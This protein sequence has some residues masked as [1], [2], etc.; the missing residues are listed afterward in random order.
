MARSDFRLFLTF[1]AELRSLWMRL[2]S[3]APN[4]TGWGTYSRFHPGKAHISR[5]RRTWKA[6]RFATRLIN[7]SA[8]AAS[9]LQGSLQSLELLLRLPVVE[10]LVYGLLHVL[11]AVRDGR[12][13][14]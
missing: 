5:A 6:V 4:G 11:G 14:V 8:L 2:E 10:V 13:M 7:R 9:Q 3:H 12:E 1:V